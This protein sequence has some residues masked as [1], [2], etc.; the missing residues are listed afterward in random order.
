MLKRKCLIPNTFSYLIHENIKDARGNRQ[1]EEGEE[2][3]E[4]PRRGVHGCVKTLGSEMEVQL[5][6]LLLK[7]T[8]LN[9]NLNQGH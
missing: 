5:R 4:E 9:A 2:K 6:Q 1:R 3:S 8:N 7:K